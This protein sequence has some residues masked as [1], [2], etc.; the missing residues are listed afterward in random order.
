MTNMAQGNADEMNRCGGEFY[1]VF[2]GHTYKSAFGA[3]VTHHVDGVQHNDQEDEEEAEL[4]AR[5]YD[6]HIEVCQLVDIH[7]AGGSFM[8]AKYTPAPRNRKTD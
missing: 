2:E 8:G 5:F 7:G 4:D 3:A 1:D 6:I